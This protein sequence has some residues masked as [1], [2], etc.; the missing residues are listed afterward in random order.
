MSSHSFNISC[1]HALESARRVVVD[2]PALL[3]L[4]VRQAV[5]HKVLPACKL[6]ALGGRT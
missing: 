4:L 2:S 1:A 5:T 3:S 6:G